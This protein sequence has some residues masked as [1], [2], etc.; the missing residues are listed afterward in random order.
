MSNKIEKR[1]SGYT[2]R[3]PKDLE[4]EFDSLVSQI[5]EAE[6]L[7]EEHMRLHDKF[8]RLYSV[9]SVVET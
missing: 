9:Y 6:Y 4:R 7:S 1:V 3:I 5:R 8:F 2:F